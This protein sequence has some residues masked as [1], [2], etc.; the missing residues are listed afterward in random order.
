MILKKVYIL[1]LIGVAASG[2]GVGLDTVSGTPFSNSW[3]LNSSNS[4]NYSFNSSKIDCTSNACEL[5]S[6]FLD[7]ND[8]SARF[9]GG[10]LSGVTWDA[11]NNYLRLNQTGTPTNYSELD[12]S[13]APASGALLGIWHLDDSSSA[14]SIA[15]SS[16]AGNS[17]THI[18]STTTLGVTGKL[19]TAANFDGVSGCVSATSSTTF[20]FPNTTFSVAFWFNTTN[21][22]G[23][24]VANGG[25]AGSMGW[26]VQ[27]MAGGYV[28]VGLKNTANQIIS[29]AS[30]S[31][32]LN[33]GNWHHVVAVATTNTVTE[34]S[35]LITLY[36]DGLQNEQTVYYPSGGQAGPYD[37]PGA[38][39]GLSFGGRG[40]SPFCSGPYFAGLLDEVAIWSTGLNATQVQ[41][42]YNRQSANYAGTFTS[43]VMTASSAQSWSG[44]N[45]TSTLPFFKEL[46]DSATSESQ[47]NYSSQ[48][49]S[50][51]SGNVALWHL[52]EI[53]GT[54][55]V[56]SVKDH[57]GQGNHA[58][59]VNSPVFGAYG[60]LD[61]A[62]SF[63]G[64]QYIQV[65]NPSSSLLLLNSLSMSAW[66]KPTA[67]SAYY[68]ILD[69]GI[70]GGVAYTLETDAAGHLVYSH[71][72]SVTATNYYCT[73]TSLLSLNTWQHVLANRDAS[74]V[75]V[76]LYIN[77][78]FAGS[79]SLAQPPNNP[80][81][82]TGVQP[83]IG[84]GTGQYYGTI[85]EVAIW[86]RKLGDGT[87]GTQ[88]E[89]FELYRRGANRIK[90]QVRS[91]SDSACVAGSPPWLG[92]D[93]TN[94]TYFSELNNNLIQNDGADLSTSDSVLAGL[95]SILFSNFSSLTVATNFYFQYRAILESD[96]SSSNCIYSGSANWC[97]PELQSVSATPS[98][99]DS[100]GDSVSSLTGFNY[101]NLSSFSESGV[102]CAAGTLYN[103]SNDGAHWYYWNGS[104]WTPA[105]GTTSTANSAATVSAAISTFPSQVGTGQLYFKAFL[106]SNGSGVCQ[107]GSVTVAGTQ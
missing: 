8:T 77:G 56:G 65:A 92:T 43:R 106:Q 36:I 102:S 50:L 52:D 107:I 17:L 66:I 3:N 15:D 105:N 59:P 68:I 101:K 1:F 19:L 58:T 14:T 91:C 61:T 79:C 25:D 45:W 16:G 37:S 94:Q 57:S 71:Y 84:A 7:N 18:Y 27:F 100:S 22:A 89:I 82:V 46:P 54:S 30:A 76:S 13:W 99:Y 44:I 72:N 2:C 80:N 63:S 21:S 75:N 34:A 62:A 5:T 39:R 49:T 69:G 33:D 32:G 96:D 41:T 74:G 24:M 53:A 70:T 42:I 104:A 4:A 64:N 51:M 12:S 10:S 9:G 88:N 67:F 97:S 48:T 23:T 40:A 78:R 73:S 86:S 28:Q 98:Q 60:K 6:E 31:G 29:L 90:Y 95:P 87:N 55:G 35:N 26:N 93:G 47:A 83:S 11:T 38:A 103:L 81:S 20:A 85:D